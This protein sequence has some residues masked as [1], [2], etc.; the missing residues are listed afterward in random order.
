MSTPKV[1]E[2]ILAALLVLLATMLQIGHAVFTYVPVVITP[3]D[4]LVHGLSA[5]IY[6]FVVQ[7]PLICMIWNRL[8][9]SVFSVKK[10]RY[11]HALL[12]IL[13]ASFVV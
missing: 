10:V 12:L 5:S 3:W 4:I 11:S 6:V 1:G 2:V 7:A 9:C 13:M 8:L